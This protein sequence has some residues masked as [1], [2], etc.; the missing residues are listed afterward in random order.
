MT[1]D[2]SRQ[3]G[4]WQA[5]AGGTFAAPVDPLARTVFALLVLACI[6]AFFITQRLKHTPTAVQDF[7]RTPTFSPRSA[8]AAHRQEQLSFKLD[9]AEAATVTII[10]AGGSA[11]ATLVR[12]HPIPRYKQFSLRWNGRR[13]PPRGYAQIVSPHGHV[14]LVPGNVGPLGAAQGIPRAGEPPGGGQ[15]SALALELHAGG[16]VSAPRGVRRWR[17]RSRAPA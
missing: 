14:T 10:D 16:R 3:G 13:G 15:G 4:G 8:V 6:A 1:I 5:G 12:N 9:R 7:E 17:P 2:E 11:V